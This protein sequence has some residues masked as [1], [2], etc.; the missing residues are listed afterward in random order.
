MK[1]GS[2][3]SK[4]AVQLLLGIFIGVFVTSQPTTTYNQPNDINDQHEKQSNEKNTEQAQ[5]TLSEAV[6]SIPSHI[7]L[8]NQSFLMGELMSG[9]EKISDTFRNIETPFRKALVVIFRLII[10]PNAP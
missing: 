10:A 2:A 4:S 5:I 6:P 3:I 7:N 9:I 8:N 1:R